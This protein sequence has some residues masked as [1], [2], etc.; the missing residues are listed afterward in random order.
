MMKQASFP[1]IMH[2][3]KKQLKTVLLAQQQ[4]IIGKF[5]SSKKTRRRLLNIFLGMN[6][7]IE[8]PFGDIERA[9]VV[10]L[11]QIEL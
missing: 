6:D 8:P 1:I 5:L 11:I 7:E 2:K 4:T 9:L 10:G 3:K